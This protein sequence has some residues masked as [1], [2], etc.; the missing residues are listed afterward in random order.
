MN[1][2][3]ISSSAH[4]TYLAYLDSFL[5]KPNYRSEIK[6]PKIHERIA[7]AK[8]TLEHVSSPAYR[9]SLVGV[10]DVDPALV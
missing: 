3:E 5:H 7:K 1:L 6:R 2:P 9:E 8:F 4:L 10:I